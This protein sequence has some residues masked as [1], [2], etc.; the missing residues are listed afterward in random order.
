MN[1]IIEFCSSNISLYACEA[2]KILDADPNL[3]VVEY[4]C[5]SNCEL[6]AVSM[7]CIVNG[8]IVTAEAPKEL[9]ENVYQFLKENPMF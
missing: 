6:C 1:P 3:D 9:V 7:F 4:S 2:F 5:T 8:E